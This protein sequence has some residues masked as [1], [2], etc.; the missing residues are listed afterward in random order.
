MVRNTI[1]GPTTLLVAYLPFA[2]MILALIFLIAQPI[3]W[4]LAIILPTFVF[5]AWRSAIKLSTVSNVEKQTG[6]MHCSR[7]RSPDA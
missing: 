1:S 4:V 2:I 5:L 3:V 7:K 6:A